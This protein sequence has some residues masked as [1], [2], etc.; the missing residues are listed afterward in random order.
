MVSPHSGAFFALLPNSDDHIFYP[1]GGGQ[2]FVDL[3]GQASHLAVPF[4]LEHCAQKWVPVL[5]KNNATT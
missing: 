4:F 2:M 1:R 3:Y 5:R